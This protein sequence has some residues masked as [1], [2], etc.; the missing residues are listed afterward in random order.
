[1]SES[2]LLVLEGVSRSFGGLKA[3][4]NVSLA[5]REG[6][7]SA[8]IGPNGAGKTTLF[9][10]MSGFLKPDAG[11]VRFAGQDITGR[12]PHR[13]AALGMTRTFQIVKPFAAQTVRENI[14][15]GAHLHLRGRTAALDAAAKVA[16]EV[17][18]GDMLDQPELIG[19][20][21]E[22]KPVIAARALAT[23]PKLL[24]LD[25]PAAGLNGAEAAELGRLI[26]RIRDG[27]VTTLLVE[28]HMELIMD[29]SDEIFVLNF[30]QSLAE[31]TPAEIKNDPA[32]IAAYLGDESSL[33]EDLRA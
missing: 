10:L 2:S 3:V 12:E 29:I 1:M 8:L 16:H 26:R 32:V 7:L 6:S 19:R 17:G 23:E 9:A 5:V 30:G 15:V 27:G 24:L 25:E 20:A 14:A 28:H 31:G 13:N 33:A 4:Q 21:H 22:L 18:L 11:S